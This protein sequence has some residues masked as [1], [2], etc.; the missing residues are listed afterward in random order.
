MKSLRDEKY[1]FAPS[2]PRTIFPWLL[3]LGSILQIAFSIGKVI[4][5]NGLIMGRDVFPTL[6][7]SILPP[8][9]EIGLISYFFVVLKC[10]KMYIGMLPENGGNALTDR[11]SLLGI[12]SIIFAPI[13][14]IFSLMPTVGLW[15]PQH[16]RTF[17]MCYF[18][19]IGAIAWLSGIVTTTALKYLI[20][21]LKSHI[22]NFPETL[23]DVKAVLWRTTLAYYLLAVSIFL[24][25]FSFVLCGFSDVFLRKA[26]YL[27]LF[28][29]L[30]C[31]P[32][33]T[34]LI[35]TVS[36][37]SQST[38]ISRTKPFADFAGSDI[39]PHAPNNSGTDL[40]DY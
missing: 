21:E 9:A 24:L 34:I 16:Q 19:G 7:G 13:Y 3:N 40:Q 1:C 39:I 5:S 37:T 36:R 4:S 27:I 14:I 30:C 23:E 33:S 8:L 2:D 29:Q 6:L 10:L 26:T 18:F 15:Y 25:G 20:E 32:A 22:T 11:F 12:V 31:P 28:Q 17:A 35:L 38:Q